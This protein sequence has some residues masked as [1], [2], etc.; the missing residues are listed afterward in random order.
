MWLFGRHRHLHLGHTYLALHVCLAEAADH[1]ASY[2]WRCTDC[3]TAMQE[4]YAAATANPLAERQLEALRQLVTTLAASS[5]HVSTLCRL[6]FSGSL[7]L[8]RNGRRACL[9]ML[10]VPMLG[11]S[12]IQAICSHCHAQLWMLIPYSFLADSQASAVHFDL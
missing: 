1:G 3:H 7:N 10:E 8:L 2:K 5:S 9:H 4:A 11:Q 6:P 12:N